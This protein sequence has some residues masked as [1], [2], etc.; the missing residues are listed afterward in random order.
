[1]KNDVSVDFEREMAMFELLYRS[2]INRPT[3]FPPGEVVTGLL[4]SLLA[5]LDGVAS[6][7]QAGSKRK[8]VNMSPFHCSRILLLRAPAA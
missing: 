5:L 6:P 7:V 3:W 4:H 8:S 1:M 2:G